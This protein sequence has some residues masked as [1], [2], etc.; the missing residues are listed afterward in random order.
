VTILHDEHS[1][2]QGLNE[3]FG[4]EGF[5][6]VPILHCEDNDPLLLRIPLQAQGLAKEELVEHTSC[7]PGHKKVYASMDWVDRY[8]TNMGML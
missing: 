2:L 5:D 6:H 4:V 1:E 3:S 8:T 7:R